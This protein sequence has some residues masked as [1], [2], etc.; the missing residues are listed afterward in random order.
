MDLQDREYD[1]EELISVVEAALGIGEVQ[2][3]PPAETADTGSSSG[4]SRSAHLVDV[5]PPDLFESMNDILGRTLDH[6]EAIEVIDHVRSGL[7]SSMVSSSSDAPSALRM[8]HTKLKNCRLCANHIDPNPTMPNYNLSDPDVMVVTSAPWSGS[9]ADE[10]M[11]K[12]LA[13]AGFTSSRIMLTSSYRCNIRGN[14]KPNPDV[15][16]TCVNTYLM[17]E[18][19]LLNPK[20][21]IVLG[22]TAIQNVVGVRKP[23]V[24]EVSNKVFWLGPWPFLAGPAPASAMRQKSS[25][26]ALENVFATAYKFV[27]G[28]PQ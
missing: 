5:I 8:L 1:D 24:S 12:A 18:I 11:V 4:P 7:T 23:K 27:Y 17:S 6:D 13:E 21:I 14:T 10:Y 28:E 22:S 16:N 3:K 15:V 20:M 19:N 2:E 26:E 9:D 25:Q